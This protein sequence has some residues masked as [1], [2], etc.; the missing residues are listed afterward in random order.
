MI[1][2][3]TFI[4]TLLLSHTARAMPA[5]G[6]VAPPEELYDTTFTDAQHAPPIAVSNVTWSNYYG[7]PD[8]DTKK[9][10]CS[11]LAPLYPH[12]KNF[13]HFPYIGGVRGGLIPCG[14]C[15]KLRN[16]KPPYRT[17]YITIMNSASNGYNTSKL[18]FNALNGG[19]GTRLQAEHSV[20][21][22]KLCRGHPN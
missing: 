14:K 2:F 16:V 4:L 19:P 9:V 12:F 20:V 17:I 8:G 6:D 3:T 21:D 13:H 22:S 1:Y 5:C 10:V 18:A 11:Q 15:V 7:N